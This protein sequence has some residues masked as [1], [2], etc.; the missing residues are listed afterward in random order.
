MG[1]MI[2]PGQLKPLLRDGAELALIDVR[3]QGV[4]FHEHLLFASCIPLSHLELRIADLLP[5]RTVRVVLCDGGDDGLAPR[6]AAL[7]RQFGYSDVKVLDGGVRAW[8]EAGYEVFSGVNVVSKAF[9]EY[10]EHRYDTPRLSAEDLAARVAR[11]EN[12][13]IL[14]SRPM[15][16][17]T[18][19]S[20]PGGVDCPGAELVYRVFDAA[21]DPDTLVVV[22]CAGRT[23]SIIGAQSLINAGIPNRVMALKNGTMGWQLAGL[24]V[25]RG[26]TRHA[27][28]PTPAGLAR[29]RAAAAKVAE[30]F[31]VDTIDLNGL[32]AWQSECGYRTLYVLDVRTAAEFAAS[33]LPGS[34]HAPGGQLVQA[35][36]EYIATRHARVVLVDSDGVRANMTASWLMQMGWQDVRVLKDGAQA[37]L[38]Q[39]IVPPTLS[40]FVAAPVIEPRALQAELEGSGAVLLDLDTSLRFRRQ[41]I[42]GARWAV[43]A[44][45]PEVLAALGESPRIVLT[46]RD[47][48]LAHYAAQDLHRLRP[49]WPVLVLQG[50]TQAWMQEGLPTANGAEGFLC[51]PNDIW[52]KPYE[53]VG[54]VR[55]AMENYLTWEVNLIPQIH[56]DGDAVFR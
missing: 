23:R 13:V 36:D 30:N 1:P 32:R 35:T 27:T 9:G 2:G 16:E 4:Y 12:L 43:R 34:R 40:G 19:I 45:L 49:Q 10:I 28:D 17:Y 42:P 51:E 39:G 24:E 48:L 18:N 56:R 46:S 52:Y 38:E 29:A 41:H 53:Q 47:G 15:E 31:G 22:N 33:H 21:P 5:R 37:L 7:L 20:I 3:E 6:A 14:D 11:G 55:Q 44:R 54:G 8:R 25:S 26:Q 50:G